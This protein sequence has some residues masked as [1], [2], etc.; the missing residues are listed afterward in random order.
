MG[1]DETRVWHRVNILW[2]SLLYVTLESTNGPIFCICRSEGVYRLCVHVF[3]HKDHGVHQGLSRGPR[4]FM[5][6]WRMGFVSVLGVLLTQFYSLLFSLL[7]PLLCFSLSPCSSYIG[8]FLILWI[9]QIC[10]LHKLLTP[11]ASLGVLSH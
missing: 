4:L 5:R 2:L 3:S 1:N 7:S 8:I 10:C 11:L 9:C 6:E